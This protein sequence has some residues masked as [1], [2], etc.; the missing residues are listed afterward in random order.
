MP[1][2]PTDPRQN[3]QPLNSARYIDTSVQYADN[4][5][6]R[7]DCCGHDRA[8]RV[9]TKMDVRG[10]ESEHVRSGIRCVCKRANMGPAPETPTE[11]IP[12]YAASLASSTS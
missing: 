5:C 10:R 2:M 12:V 9:Q 6:Q 7:P 1:D 4:V 11:R 8:L 3:L